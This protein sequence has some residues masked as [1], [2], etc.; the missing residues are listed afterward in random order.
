MPTSKHHFTLPR[1]FLSSSTVRHGFTLIEL[2]VVISIISLL[3]ALLLPALTSAREAAVRTQC[4][5]NLRQVGITTTAYALDT[6]GAFP[7]TF[8]NLLIND[9]DGRSS[10]AAFTG[11]NANIDALY[12]PTFWHYF[13]PEAFGKAAN[14]QLYGPYKSGD[15]ILLG[16]NK[17]AGSAKLKP[18]F[19]TGRFFFSRYVDRTS[20]FTGITS[21]GT[22]VGGYMTELTM[23]NSTRQYIT[24]GTDDLV[25]QSAY[26]PARIN[27]GAFE[28]V[29]LTQ[30]ALFSCSNNANSGR[31]ISYSHIR[32]SG[33]Y[34]PP[35]VPI[36]TDGVNEVLADG[37]VE[38]YGVGSNL[39]YHISDGQAG[40]GAVL[41]Q[42]DQ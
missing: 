9:A 32:G 7:Y 2:L 12:C 39:L 23:A 19:W 25:Q 27:L 26:S 31:A 37:H 1:A 10:M 34:N 42:D 3:I 24:L 29:P 5:S 33:R 17:W 28:P 36:P 30:I 16:Y 4:A 14:D 20:G 6:N 35:I 8:D 40:G 38:W 41:V 15:S 22:V 18:L 21:T 11:Y 13:R